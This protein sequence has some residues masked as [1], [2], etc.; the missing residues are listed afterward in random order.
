MTPDEAMQ[1]DFPEA[2]RS[3]FRTI[4]KARPEVRR[5]V[6]AMQAHDAYEY[7]AKHGDIYKRE[8]GDELYKFGVEFGWP[9][10]DCQRLT[11]GGNERA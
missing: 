2:I 11:G 1:P 6:F 10:D 5:T 7:D 9:T 8:I 4:A 3:A